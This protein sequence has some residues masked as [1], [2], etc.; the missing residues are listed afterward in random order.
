MIDLANITKKYKI[1]STDGLR[2]KLRYTLHVDES[3][4]IAALDNI[5]IHVDE[6]EI[7]GVL[8]P[9]G[10]GKTTLIKIVAGLLIPEQGTATINGFDSIKDRENVR[11]S[12]NILMSGGWV[13]FDYKLSIYFNLKYW[14]TLGGIPRDD[15]D[16][17]I[18]VV[19]CAVEME[20]KKFE[21]PEKLSAGMR[22]KLNLARCLL[23]DRPI[24]LLDEPTVNL[25]PYTAD[26]IRKYI[27]KS[28]RKERK[29][30]LI[31]THNLWEAEMLCDRIAIL[32]NGT[33]VVL[34]EVKKIIQKLGTE[35]ATLKVVQ[36]PSELMNELTSLEWVESVTKD[37]DTLMVHGKI[38]HN[39]PLL[40]D[41][42]RK[43]TEI[44][45]ID[46]AE[47]SLNE[48]FL[49]LIKKKEPHAET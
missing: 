32:D 49:N 38:K 13:V 44:K 10:A 22:Q 23:T 7:F 43:Y 1:S 46:I 30:A 41:V 15:I 3:K 40:I 8:G 14:A 11:T 24:Y 26:F 20:D 19:L 2:K 33:I 9:T 47:S 12:V 16:D 36:T 27:S 48:I 28:I 37:N 34:D 6:G 31:A 35:T 21:S 42:C 39:V 5:T 29:T 18:D 4:Y 25:D 17:R 45:E